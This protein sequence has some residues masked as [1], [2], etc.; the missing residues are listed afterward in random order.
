VASQ[1]QLTVVTFVSV[2]L[3]SIVS[4]VYG[5][6]YRKL[7]KALQDQQAVCNSNAEELIGSMRTVRSFGAEFQ[8]IREYRGG[9]QLLLALGFQQ[10]YAYVGY[11]FFVVGAPLLVTVA[12][13]FF[14]AHMVLDGQVKAGDMVAFVFYQQ[15]L[16]EAIGSIGDVFTGL[17][18][19][20]GAA[21]K[22]FELIDRDP[23]ISA[24]GDLE[25]SC[26]GVWGCGE[27][28]TKRHT[29]AAT[30]HVWDV[31]AVTLDGPRSEHGGGGGGGGVEGGG[32]RGFMGRIEFERVSLVYPS[33]PDTQVL[34]RIS[35]CIGVANVL[36]V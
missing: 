25:P 34:K 18:S 7:T 3:V 15:A 27:G 17:M 23:K 8:E 26:S 29:H 21:D 31:A 22:V 28:G 32:R 11:M 35:F 20:V 33:R 2:P 30:G 1:W 9:L 16:S 10:A 24:A 12:V 6:F 13:L 36:L 14:G 5:G 19:A 4:K